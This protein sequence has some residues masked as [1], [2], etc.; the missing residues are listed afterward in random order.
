M[1]KAMKPPL[2]LAEGDLVQAKHHHLNL[3]IVLLCAWTPQ[4]P[5]YREA[6]Q[7]TERASTEHKTVTRSSGAKRSR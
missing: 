2:S 6:V 4:R 5:R 3:R 7:G 1:P